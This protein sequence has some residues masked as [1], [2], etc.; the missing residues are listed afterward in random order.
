MALASLTMFKVIGMFFEFLGCIGIALCFMRGFLAYLRNLLDL[1]I[2]HLHVKNSA[3]VSP[4]TDEAVEEI[5]TE[6]QQ[7]EAE[8]K[9]SSSPLKV[10]FLWASC[11]AMGYAIF[12]MIR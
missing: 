5:L 12:Y 1:A 6:T 3:V 11:L 9:R 2:F 8:P 7:A 10:L 4:E